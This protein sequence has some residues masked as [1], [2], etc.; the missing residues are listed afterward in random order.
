ME[1]NKYPPHLSE[2]FSIV[3]NKDK[4]P[5]QSVQ[6]DMTRLSNSPDSSN[7][8][9]NTRAST[10]Q[11]H[12]RYNK[13]ISSSL[14]SNS[15]CLANLDM[16]ITSKDI[17]QLTKFLTQLK[18]V[19][20][21]YSKSLE[22]LAQDTLEFSNIINDLTQLK[23]CPNDNKIIKNLLD[24]SGLF[25]IITN[26]HL[27]LANSINTY[28][29]THLTN[30][31]SKIDKYYNSTHN[32]FIKFD[33]LQSNK[34][35]QL[36]RDYYHSNKP[37]KFKSKNRFDD[38]LIQ[39]RQNLNDLQFQV[40]EMELNRFNY[41]QDLIQFND[42]VFNDVINKLATISKIHLEINENIA[43]KNWP[44]GGLDQL[45][46]YSDD[47]LF[48]KDNMKEEEEE[49][50]LNEEIIEEILEDNHTS[51]ESTDVSDTINTSRE[52]D[53]N[54]NTPTLSLPNGEI[55]KSSPHKRNDSKTSYFSIDNNQINTNQNQ[56]SIESVDPEYDEE[57]DQ[58]FSLPLTVT[59]PTQDNNIDIGSNSSDN[60]SD[61]IPLSPIASQRSTHL[62]DHTQNNNTFIDQSSI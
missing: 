16:I 62:D 8:E 14:N 24:S 60:E 56:N 54:N 44:D 21:R 7:V 38:N 1:Q 37:Q 25:Q 46:N 10:P 3:N 52:E 6:D 49:E 55:S 11:T 43:R 26:H 15:S 30:L 28:L 23:I 13:S 48:T 9:P 51:H 17:E 58:S 36:K 34:L 27:I 47:L 32:K 39:I 5:T 33:Q 20:S 35:N 50:D 61:K 53:I 12:H 4:T 57:Q 19:S 31:I 22:T 41:Y 45:L 29:I 2:F 40:N 42:T 18:D 59:S